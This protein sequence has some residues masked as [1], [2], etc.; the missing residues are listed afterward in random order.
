MASLPL[1]DAKPVTVQPV[2]L[3]N[4]DESTLLPLSTLIGRSSYCF[5]EGSLSLTTASPFRGLR[6]LVSGSKQRCQ[7]GGFDLDLSYIPCEDGT[8]RMLALGLPATGMLEPLYRNPLWEVRAFLDKYHRNRYA[9]VNLCNERDYLDSDFPDAISVLR[10]RCDDHHAPP[11][12]LILRFCEFVDLVLAANDENVVAVHCKAG[13]GRTGVML[14]CYLMWSQTTGSIDA[15]ESL[16]RFRAARTSDGN[17]VTKPSQ[18]RYVRHFASL[19]RAP[20]QE[21]AQMLVGRPVR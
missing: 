14:S 3:R 10:F 21:R 1:A 4:E 7:R 2:H 8:R 11:L 13:I 15:D 6:K 20:A 19:A 16:S 17:A 9:V 5:L 18:I 12:L